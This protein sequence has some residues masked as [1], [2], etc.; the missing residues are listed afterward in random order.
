MRL[1]QLRFSILLLLAPGIAFAQEI[2][3]KSIPVA[4][5][6]QFL[7]NPSAR[8]AM[9]GVSIALDDRLG[10]P[11]DN[12][13]KGINIPGSYVAVTP[14][15][16]NIGAT[17]NPE[18]HATRTLPLGAMMRK[19]QFFGGTIL[20]WQEMVRRPNRV[21]CFFANDWLSSFRELEPEE[22]V[23]TRDNLYLS[24][25][26]GVE[27]RE[28]LSVGFSVFRAFLNGIEGVQLL[29]STGDDVDQD[30][31]LHLYK[32]GLYQTW[33]DGRT[34]EALVQFHRFKMAHAMTGIV[35][36]DD[37]WNVEPRTEKDETS[38]VSLRLGYTH[39]LA[40]GWTVG[41]RLVGDWKTHP[42]IPNYDLMQIPRDPGNTG[43]YNIGV[44]FSRKVKSA[45]Y[46]FDLIYEPIWS[47]T[48][49]NAEEEIL[50]G[51]GPG[52]VKP[53]EMTVENYFRFHNAIFRMGVRREGR[54]EFGV[55]LNL[56]AIRYR[57]NQEN[58]VAPLKRTLNE[59][60]GEWTFTAGVG[61][62]F[63]GVRVHYLSIISA[64]TGQPG[65]ANPGPGMAEANASL[66][67]FVIAPAGA[68]DLLE[69]RVWTHRLSVI[70][71]LFE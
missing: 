52:V 62:N 67:S 58:F 38:G 4:T 17:T 23:L 9:G 30:G 15:Y 61:Y 71:P 31:S 16:Y 13:A 51:D 40:R 55:G 12:P 44:G 7:L 34:A 63:T 32:A 11:F 65:L 5:G 24:L 26:G 27:I 25:L 68:L 10:D 54:L 46:G 53:G 18:G 48:W 43:A 42:K 1:R 50:I 64:G 21:C 57:L 14:H 37:H 22:S 45:I 28:G 33:E 47:H 39:P 59:S 2:G 6:S 49:A 56:H 29:Y 69:A 19:G 36:E 20:A 70:V 41:A 8:T 3:V 66:S 60:W 35:W